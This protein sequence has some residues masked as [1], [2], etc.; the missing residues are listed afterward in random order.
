MLVASAAASGEG[1]NTEQIT[2][3]LRDYERFVNAGDAAAVGGLYT[4]G[5]ILV[6][7]RFGV[8]ADAEAIG[9]FY[10]YAFDALDLDLEFLIDPED[11]IVVG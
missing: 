6:P 2:Q 3:I 1:S 11:I 7:D 10:A 4:E 9:G 8:F 5:S